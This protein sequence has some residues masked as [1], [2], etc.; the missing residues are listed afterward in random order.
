MWRLGD[1]F[2]SFS[3][4]RLIRDPVVGRHDA[5]EFA[6][7]C[8]RHC[9]RLRRTAVAIGGLHVSGCL[10]MLDGRAVDLDVCHDMGV[11]ILAG[12]AGGVSNP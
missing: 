1:A 3:S 6:G 2:N 11:A 5:L 4:S 10:S 9:S 7:G 8:V 12:E